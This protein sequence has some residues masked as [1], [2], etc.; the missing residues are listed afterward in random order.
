MIVHLAVA[1]V[2]GAAPFAVSQ[3]AKATACAVRLIGEFSAPTRFV[4]FQ[5]SDIHL[6][7]NYINPTE[8]LALHS[9]Y[10]IS[11]PSL[12]TLI[13]KGYL[14]VDATKKNRVCHVGVAPGYHFVEA[15]LP[16]HEASKSII[17]GCGKDDAFQVGIASL[18][19]LGTQFRLSTDYIPCDVLHRTQK[20]VFS[21]QSD[22]YGGCLSEVFYGDG[23]ANQQWE[24]QVR[25]AARVGDSHDGTKP[26]PFAGGKAFATD[27]IGLNHF[28]G[29]SAGY[30][31]GF[32]HFLVLISGDSLHIGRGAPQ[33]ER[34]VCD[35][36]G[37]DSRESPVVVFKEPSDSR[38][39]RY[40]WSGLIFLT[41]I[42]GLLGYIVWNS[43]IKRRD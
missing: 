38:D 31:G 33:G 14:V 42:G 8:R 40:W 22:T 21:S 12:V 15:V 4:Q 20:S 35:G 32:H 5:S 34:K 9:C 30:L 41:G 37:G 28:E 19:S 25:K 27:S 13:A 36:H 2:L 7:A 10:L 29:G 18:F 43:A 17:D 3:S 1:A 24:F 11:K 6:S 26:R 39:D 23:K 16:N